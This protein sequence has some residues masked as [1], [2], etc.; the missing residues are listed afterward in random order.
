MT[1]RLIPPAEA[2]GGPSR[3]GR[4][5]KDGYLSPAYSCEPSSH[6]RDISTSRS[7]RPLPHHLQYVMTDDPVHSVNQSGADEQPVWL[8]TG[9]AH[10]VGRIL[11]EMAL[12]HGNRVVATTDRLEDLWPLV[13]RY[14]SMVIPIELDV[15]DECADREIV[16]RVVE[17]MGR[18]DVVV[19]AAGY[20]KEGAVDD[21]RHERERVQTNLFGAL[22]VS[23]AALEYMCANAGGRIVEVFGL[24]GWE[25]HRDRRFY[26]TSRRVLTGFS[27]HLAREV[28]PFG[29]EVSICV[30]TELYGE[31]SADNRARTYTLDAY[32]PE[33]V[34]VFV[35]PCNQ[36]PADEA[37]EL[38]TAT[39]THIQRLDEE[40]QNPSNG[41]PPPSTVDSHP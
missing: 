22:W 21:A 12:R 36:L 7:R 3:L 40:R 11:A 6:A 4:T 10:G 27:E 20:D 16:Q 18:L 30:A 33:G 41:S 23:Q 37:E 25:R 17:I 32:D 34:E 31:W 28:A 5:H 29:V 26:D 38:A 14:E 19:N 15:N 39:L 9:A 2:E 1:L 8:V 24:N 13:D 35:E